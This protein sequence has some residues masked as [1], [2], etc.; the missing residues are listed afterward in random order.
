[1]TACAR[2]S[3]R[4]GSSTCATSGGLTYIDIE[5][6]YNI[7]RGSAWYLYQRA[8]RDR[9]VVLLRRT[10]IAV[11][12][13]SGLR[14]SE[15]CGLTWRDVN[16]DKRRLDVK[17]AKTPTGVR[18]VELSPWVVDELRNYRAALGFRRASRRTLCVARTS[19][20]CWSRGIRCRT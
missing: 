13:G 3:V 18:E 10:T 11:L 4:C 9:P 16:L 20:W 6:D 15:M 8:T 14:V 7:P 2:A 12:V 19:R 5:N 17:D 1:M